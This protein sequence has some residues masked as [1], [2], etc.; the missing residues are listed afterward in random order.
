MSREK[1]QDNSTIQT[2]RTFSTIVTSRGKETST[3]RRNC[4]LQYITPG[5]PICLE[6]SLRLQRELATFH[7]CLMHFL[8]HHLKNR[9]AQ[10]MCPDFFVFFCGCCM[11]ANKTQSCI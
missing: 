1:H 3:P 7:V 2:N 5:S 11:G 10:K 8:K 9:H 6:E 4:Y